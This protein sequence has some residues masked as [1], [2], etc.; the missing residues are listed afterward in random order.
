MTSEE[1]TLMYR[2][3]CFR[4]DL[5]ATVLLCPLALTLTACDGGAGS[6]G[7]AASD[8]DT[9]MVVHMD[10]TPA[11]ITVPVGATVTWTFDDGAIAHDVVFDDVDV[12]SELI[13]D[14]TFQHVFTEAGTYAYHCSL[15]PN[16]TGTVEV[17]S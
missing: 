3:R 15:H 10:Y 12:A 13:T 17:T 7:A 16:M 5:L 8:V 14:G 2:P 4:S 6:A 11:S 9:V 1:R